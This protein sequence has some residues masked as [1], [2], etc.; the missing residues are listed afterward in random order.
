MFKIMLTS[1]FKRMESEYENRIKELED[2]LSRVKQDER[3]YRELSAARFNAARMLFNT[4]FI[5]YSH[6]IAIQRLSDVLYDDKKDTFTYEDI[7]EIVNESREFA[8]RS[9]LE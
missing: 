3:K 4:N 6:V 1:K 9:N 5:K 8:K 2:E 7:L